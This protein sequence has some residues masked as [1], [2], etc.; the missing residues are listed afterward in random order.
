MFYNNQFLRIPNNG[1]LIIQTNP[2]VAGTP[3]Q[4]EDVSLRVA[5]PLAPSGDLMHFGD[6]AGAASSCRNVLRMNS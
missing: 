5:L 4:A 6:G 3:A 1:L 2:H